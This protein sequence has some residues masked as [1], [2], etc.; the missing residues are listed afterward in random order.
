[1]MCARWFAGVTCVKL[2]YCI[3]I[4]YLPGRCDCTHWMQP[5]F[6][7]VHFKCIKMESQS[8]AKSV[9]AP[10]KTIHF[11]RMKR[12]SHSYELRIHKSKLKI[13]RFI[14]S[15]SVQLKR[16]F[17][18]LNSTDIAHA[19]NTFIYLS[20]ESKPEVNKRIVPKSRNRS[21]TSEP[22]G[23]GMCR[24]VTFSAC[25]L[26]KLKSEN[27]FHIYF[28]PPFYSSFSFVAREIYTHTHGAQ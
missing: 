20:A 18:I 12:T 17:S 11:N 3:S 14:L 22:N 10:L 21:R 19:F 9:S 1:M 7:Q 5:L 15:H 27:I 2:F 16:V 28:V 25:E 23:V 13:E 8:H 24:Y 6:Q 4:Y 26:S